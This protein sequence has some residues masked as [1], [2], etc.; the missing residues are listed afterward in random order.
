MSVKIVILV[1]LGGAVGAVT[2]FLSVAVLGKF[3][4]GPLSI[5]AMNSLGSFAMGALC[6]WGGG[7]EPVVRGLIAVG[8][9]GSLTTFS[10]FSMDLGVMIQQG[11]YLLS[12][13]YALLSVF[14]GVGAFLVG[15]AL[16]KGA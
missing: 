7:T 14:G 11:R 9:L 3:L 15:W 8:F 4:G 2:R 16:V 10:T 6:S 13:G 1:A 5:L 12:L